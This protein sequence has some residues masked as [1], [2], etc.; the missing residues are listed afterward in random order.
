[1]LD[2]TQDFLDEVNKV[3]VMPGDYCVSFDVKSL[4]TN[5]PLEQ[6]IKIVA[7]YIFSHPDRILIPMSKLIFVRL[8]RLNKCMMH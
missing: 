7:D 3:D 4:F 5:I 6:T 1:M 2:S 8:L